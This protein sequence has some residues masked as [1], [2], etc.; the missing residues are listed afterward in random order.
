[1]TINPAIIMAAP[2]GARKTSKDHPALPVSIGETV[3]EAVQCYTAGASILHAHVRG[4]EDEHVLD[5][6]LYQELITEMQNQLP[7]MLVQITTEAVGLYTPQQQR[8]CVKAVVPEMTS[9]ALREMTSD[10]KDLAFAK[11]FYHWADEAEVHVQHIVYNADELSKFLLLREDG[12]IPESQHCILFVL[13]RYAADFQSSPAD[14]E[15]FLKNNLSSLDWFVCAFGA[16]EQASV[17]AA[18]NHG[19]HGRIGFENNLLLP[20]GNIA[21]SSAELVTELA[22]AVTAD[23]RAIATAEQSRQLLGVRSA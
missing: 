4:L 21:S 15:P 3:T 10:F 13:G 14:L 2:N 6:G 1:V 23:G 22:K 19:G 20:D 17:H 11:S 12:V 16:Q 18:I 8:D 7:S 9:V 5:A